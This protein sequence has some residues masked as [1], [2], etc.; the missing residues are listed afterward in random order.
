MKEQ[1]SYCLGYKGN[2]EVYSNYLRSI[3]CKEH[4]MQIMIDGVQYT[5]L[6][7]LETDN[8]YEAAL[9]VRFYCDA[10]D[11]EISIRDYLF[12]LLDK[13]WDTKESFSGRRPFGNSDWEYDLFSPLVHGGFISG[14]IDEYGDVSYLDYQ[15]AYLF[16]SKLIKVAIYGD[17]E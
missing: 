3:L 5:P 15:E 16:V 10:A 11:D 9:N 8:K 6:V 2:N 1:F 12:M 14:D 13:L 4:Y 7:E 17:R